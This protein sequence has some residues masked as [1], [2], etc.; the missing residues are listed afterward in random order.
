[1]HYVHVDSFINTYNECVYCQIILR[2]NTEGPQL[3]VIFIIGYFFFLKNWQIVCFV[4]CKKIVKNVH[5]QFL[6]PKL[7]SYN[8]WFCQSNKTVQIFNLQLYKTEKEKQQKSAHLRN[9]NH[10]MFGISA[11]QTTPM[12]CQN[13]GRWIFCRSSHQFINWSFQHY[14]T[15]K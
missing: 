13:F 9:L 5:R 12:I 6:E 10:Q 7:T 14:N 2:Y 11:Q 4:K 15:V 3:K 1:M 8:C